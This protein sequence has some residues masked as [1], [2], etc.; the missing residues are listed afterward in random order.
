MF[1]RVAALML[2]LASV[3][4]TGVLRI[5]VVLNDAG[6]AATPIPRVL[7]LISDNPATAEPRRVR[8][9]ADGSVELK[10][11]PGNYTIES[12]QAVA[13]GGNAYSWTETLD[14]VAGREIV[15]DLTAKNAAITPAAAATPGAPPA[16]EADSATILAK[17]Q[18]SVVEIWTPVR[19]ASGLVVDR[20]GLIAT[21]Q[22]AIGNATDVEVEMLVAGR[23][24]KV[25]G[26]VIHSDRLTG[27]AIVRVD[28]QATAPLGALGPSCAAPAAP[29]YRD[30][31]VAI[32]APMLGGKEMADGEVTRVT[33]QAIFVD[34][35]LVR[36]AAGGPVFSEGGELLGLSSIA[37]TED[38]RGQDEVFIV[39]V[40]SVCETMAAAEKKLSGAPPRF[41]QLPLEPPR[42]LPSGIAAKSTAKKT[43]P[44]A[45]STSDFDVRLLT[46]DQL[47]EYGNASPQS[48]VAN[49]NDYIR[50]VPPVLLIRVSPQFEESFWKMLARG[51]AATQGMALPPLRSFTSNFSKMRAFCGD[52]EVTPIHPLI[53][54]RPV[55]EAASIREGLYVYARDAFGP[56]CAS[57]RL[58]LYSEKEP[59]KADT[60]TIDPRLFDQL[61]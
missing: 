13:F 40:S 48:D 51:A 20:R 39:P 43:A 9:N 30:Q 29:E 6:G 53:I 49:W 11:R 23:R 5:R 58:L 15:L 44:A 54:E 10:L 1:S 7:L 24:S 33:P 8:T 2:V 31:V 50:D 16:I 25:P 14:V 56:H 55:S 41:T 3:Q 60:R 17:W 12:D 21:S 57:V 19:H 4:D 22:R 27:T 47:R 42:T 36:D 52:N 34:L 37:I 59:D 18:N 32:A 46:P 45:L 38:R 61:K 28:P 26:V 35:R